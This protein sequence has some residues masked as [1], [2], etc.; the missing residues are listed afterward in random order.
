M[1][2]VYISLAF[3]LGIYCGSR[4]YIPPGNGLLIIA[5]LPFIAVVLQIIRIKFR[6]RGFGAFAILVACTIAFMLGTA[7][8]AAAP[9]GDDLQQYVG[10]EKVS[11]TGVVVEEPEAT[12]TSVKMTVSVREID[13]EEASGTMLV[14]TARYPTIEYG[15]MLRIYGDLELPS[16]DLEG[17]DYRA[18]LKRQGI[19]T[20]M[21]YPYVELVSEEQGPQPWQALYSFRH[22]LGEVLSQ[23]LP[24]PEGSMA[25]A[26]IL[27][28]RHDIPPSIYKDFQH[29]GTAHLLAIS[30]L[31]MSIIAGIILSASVRL[32]GKRRPT[33]FIATLGVLWL[34]A[35]LAGMSPSVMR[36]AIMI[37]IYLL[38]A[39]LG[40][41]RSGLTAVT[42]AAAVMVAV[43]PDILW[44]V[45]FQLS[46]SA[47][48]GLILIAPPLK[49]LCSRTRAPRLF[50]DSFAYSMGAISATLPLVVYYFGYV[51][52]WSLFATFFA[53]L[54]LPAIIVLTALVAFIGLFWL[55]A[56]RVIGW[57]DWLLLKYTV[58]VVQG[59]AAI[60]HAAVEIAQV[61]AW[62]VWTYYGL[63]A[64]IMWLGSKIKRLL[65]I[66]PSESDFIV[67]A[68][69]MPAPAKWI[70]ATLSIFAVLAWVAVFTAPDTGKLQVS[71]LDIGQ[72]DAI[73][74]K[75]P[76]NQYILIDGGP[77]PELACLRL[78]EEL[79]FWEHSIDM[80]VLTHGHDDHVG[81]LV[82]VLRRYDVKQI[83]YSDLYPVE[84]TVI[85][86]FDG[87]VAPPYEEFCKI[88]TE[89]GLIYTEARVGQRIDLGGGAT[90]EVLNPSSDLLEG[91]DSDIDN[92]SVVLRVAMG[93][94]SFLLTGDLY[95]DG[96]LHLVCE[97]SALDSTVLKAC[98]HGSKSSSRQY[99]LDAVSPYAAAMSYGAGNRF[100]HPGED[101]VQRLNT[102]AG[103]EL[104]FATAERG[105]ITFTT[106][107]ERLWVETENQDLP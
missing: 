77:T 104:V 79:P 49:D 50:V 24:E 43:D 10:L 80:M 18:Y 71:V 25:R 34:Y 69:P 46:F 58:T 36:A 37:S 66:Q 67:I 97:R 82:E 53:T 56:A 60:P 90:M 1:K 83:L 2:L 41:Q 6:P 28:L 45:G 5:A 14:R 32:F 70:I 93:E 23:S 22:R 102:S 17:F 65:N 106:D 62:L 26:I 75:S 94:I 86:E 48:L 64:V 19:Y 9:S 78:G 7:R 84:K 91:T 35:T 4:F 61:K 30:G 39:H 73:L 38:G 13:G 55:P 59:F 107:G 57:V 21:Y 3:V 16:D 74:V 8:F 33:Y 42:F 47:V 96:E 44:Q 92:N 103:G 100:S 101:V 76:T 27:G 63:L 88:I 72:G 85:G 12:N 20:T 89:K 98:H 40:R 31:H 54:A 15:D 52:L 11:V 99:F 95:W 29:S 105:T 87:K 81:G 68:P 51:S